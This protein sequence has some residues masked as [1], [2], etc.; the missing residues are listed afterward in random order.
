MDIKNLSD[1]VRPDHDENQG[2]PSD[3]QIL[4]G[5]L[6]AAIEQD[7]LLELKEILAQDKQLVA[8]TFRYQ[9]DKDKPDIKAPI[10]P[11]LYA[12]KLGRETIVETLLLEYNADIN[13]RL[14]GIGKT[15]LHLAA[16]Y[17]WFDTVR[18]LICCRVDVNQADIEGWTALHCASRGGHTKVARLLLENKASPELRNGKGQTALA[19]ACFRGDLELLQLLWDDGPK[20]AISDAD[21]EGFQPLHNAACDNNHKVVTWLLEKNLDIE[22]KAFKGF[23]PLLQ[24]TLKSS[25]EAAEVLLDKG[26]DVHARDT[27]NKST[28]IL[29]ASYKRDLRI[30]KLLHQYGASLLD[31]DKNGLSCFHYAINNKNSSQERFIELI[32]YLVGFGAN[33]NHLSRGDLSP[34]ASACQ[35]GRPAEV[36]FLLRFGADINRIASHSGTTALLEACSRPKNTAV[37]N[38]LLMHKA[39]TTQANRH[40]TCPLALA[41][42]L[43]HSEYVE[44]L[45]SRGCQIAPVDKLGQTPL[46]TAVVMGHFDIGLQLLKTPIYFPSNPDQWI[47]LD[48]PSKVADIGDK[49][50]EELQKRSSIPLGDLHAIMY[51][52]VAN[53]HQALAEG[54]IKADEQILHMQR[55]GA[56]F[57][58]TAA[59][60]AQPKM[61]PILSRAS[62]SEVAMSQRTAIHWAAMRGMRETAEE[63]FKLAD[64]DYP[65]RAAR[66]KV[67]LIMHRDGLGCT[68][69]ATSIKYR[70]MALTT[71]PTDLFLDEIKN[72]GTVDKDFHSNHKAQAVEI[73][74]MLAEFEKPGH[75]E[76]L[77]H[78]LVEWHQLQPSPET[79]TLEFAVQ[80]SE[81]TVVWWLLS[82]GAYSSGRHI[83]NA[84]NSLPINR[85]SDVQRQIREL[86]EHPPPTLK[87]VPNPND[88]KPP[89]L[90]DIRDT[91]SD[92]FDVNGMIVDIY[93]DG[94]SA[95]TQS[96][97]KK[98]IYDD[99][100]NKVI[101]REVRH[102]QQRF[103]EFRD[104]LQLPRNRAPGSDKTL[105]HIAANQLFRWIHLP[106]AEMQLMR[107]LANRISHD[108]NV[109]EMNYERMMQHLNLSWTE[110]A[111]GGGKHYMKPRCM[112]KD[113][114]QPPNG[115][116]IGQE[117]HTKYMALYIPYLNFGPY[118]PDM[119]AHS[120]RDDAQFESTY[121]PIQSRRS[122]QIIHK[123]LTL[124]QYFY[125]VLDETNGRDGDQVLSKF[126]DF[127]SKK[128]LVA[129]YDDD[130][131][132]AT[133]G[134][135]KTMVVDQLW[136][137]VLDESEF[138]G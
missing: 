52:A 38:Q 136:A 14:D 130:A 11:L 19:L 30:L 9:Y 125:S 40:G 55:G 107:A 110:L 104:S 111:A 83:T 77:R 115:Y 36:F 133:E 15:S 67:N 96:S 18:V 134:R 135:Q 53:G 50:V 33:I 27:W 23:T 106:V 44:L 120:H 45:I 93:A 117:K 62:L 7:D 81:A 59:Q 128:K 103:R 112:I 116:N 17:G 48:L 43:G 24:A 101:S 94:R 123:R 4:Q 29:V 26:A 28:P 13:A 98:I 39:D 54:C 37:I 6:K 10:L 72:L 8:S 42:F 57:L 49:L 138:S 71:A 69:L 70:G 131:P 74:E 102:P 58:Y 99:G 2:Q 25:Y 121:E 97:I 51:W 47:L 95:Y 31:C 41:C 109:S 88:D 118:Q 78:L 86:L 73:L 46:H 132:T 16:T 56:T 1:A 79:T 137:W 119:S 113:P 92:S 76:T 75:E 105:D 21:I 22:A 114:N 63:L 61:I 129:K 32:V 80:A 124:D 87:R 66:S 3:K 5:R 68:A 90:P 12:A 64:T 127:W 84:L 60:Y 91:S 122:R 35:L 34:L 85:P 20:T 65:I 89:K 100:P 108:S 126:V 82:N